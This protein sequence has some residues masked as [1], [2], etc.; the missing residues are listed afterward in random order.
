MIL[1]D[2]KTLLVQKKLLKMKKKNSSS[3]KCHHYNARVAIILGYHNGEVHINDQLKSIMK[4]SHSNF[5]IYLCD[6]NSENKFDLKK[7]KLSNFEKSKITIHKRLKNVGFQNNFLIALSNIPDNYDYFSFCDQDD[8]WAVNKIEKAIKMVESFPK[9]TPTLYCA[10]T[11]ITDSNCK[12]TIGYSPLFRKTPSF[13]NALVQNLGGGNT[14]L[15]N[16]S[17][18]NIISSS[19]INNKVVSHDWWCYL[20]ISGHE[21]N[22]IYD[23]DVC[24]KYRQH[25]KNLI[26]ANQ[27]WI[28]RI[29]RLNLLFKGNFKYWS[30]I[31]IKAL[32]NNYDILSEK[33]KKILND[34]IDA[35]KSSFLKR[36]ML[37]KRTGVYRQTVLGNIGLFFGFLLNKI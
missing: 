19:F 20:I 33:N 2:I 21:G 17:A 9:E 29:S 14:M 16:R 27:G 10:R 26:G 13:A 11:E 15:F 25:G 5:K 1:Q 30:E 37:F 31:N 24:L 28:S 22:I 4:Q 12:Q 32:K 18:K 36:M 8:I 35:R 6:D 3:L 23:E 7:I 34:F